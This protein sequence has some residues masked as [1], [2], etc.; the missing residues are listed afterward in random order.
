MFKNVIKSV[1]YVSMIVELSK[2]RKLTGY[3]I[4]E[5]LKSFGVEVSPGTVYYQLGMLEKEG[6]IKGTPTIR[7]TTKTVYEMTRKGM[8]ATKT[9]YEMTGKGMEASKEF[10]DMWCKMMKN[11]GV[12]KG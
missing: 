2:G 9:V 1:S 5:H 3:D 4:L 7:R 10:Q 11:I 12:G 8:E 6:Y